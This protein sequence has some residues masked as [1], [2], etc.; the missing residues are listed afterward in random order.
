MILGGCV[1]NLEFLRFTFVW[2][3]SKVAKI[4]Y[5]YLKSN[6]H[7]KLKIMKINLLLSFSLVMLLTT[8]LSAQYNVVQETERNMSF[9]SRPCFRL[10]FAKADANLVENN[11]KDYVKT[12]F[13]GKLKSDKKTDELFATNLKSSM[14]GDDP[15]GVYSTIEKTANGAVLTVW[16]DMG[17]YFLS[18]RESSGKTDEVSRSLKTF[19]YDVRRAQIGK[20]IKDQEGKLKD[21][22]T[23]QKK[24][25]RE[26]E[27]LRKDIELYK[28]KIK[29]AEDDIVKNE[30]DQ[31]TNILDTEAQR[32]SIDESK[33][34]LENV[35]N[36]RN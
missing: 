5:L 24:M 15:F 11:W 27:Q 35:E 22:E 29:K 4:R 26:N 18:R 30:K 14:L 34:R 33:R 12:N 3:P 28:I 1:T 2:P 17:T 7:T 16:F 6:A 36:E 8:A 23:K 21:L 19:Y 31:E 10:D 32:R 20:E 25:A 13:K 9:G